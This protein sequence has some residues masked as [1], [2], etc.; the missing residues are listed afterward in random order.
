M[1]FA[2]RINSFKK[3]PLY[4]KISVLDCIEIISKIDGITHIELNYPEHFENI[5]VEE[6]KEALIKHNLK[7]SG[8][9]LRYDL[10][11]LMENLLIQI[12]KLEKLQ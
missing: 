10:N 1:K 7:L 4:K 12:K 11:L 9:A 2:A 6:V 5:K 8:I 3:S